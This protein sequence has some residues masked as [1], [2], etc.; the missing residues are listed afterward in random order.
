MYFITL[1][2]ALKPAW[3]CRAGFFYISTSQ[4][5]SIEAPTAPCLLQIAGFPLK[6]FDFND[7]NHLMGWEFVNVG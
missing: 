1:S 4:R 5:L 6:C 7:N 2:S 3:P